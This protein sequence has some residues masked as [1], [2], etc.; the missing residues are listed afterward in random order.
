MSNKDNDCKHAYITELAKVTIPVIGMIGAIIMVFKAEDSSVAATLLSAGIGGYWGYASTTSQNVT[1]K[2][3][4]E[5]TSID[6][7]PPGSDS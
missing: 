7:N 4:S 3:N 1:N 5:S 6:N 2:V